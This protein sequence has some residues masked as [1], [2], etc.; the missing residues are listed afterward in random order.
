MAN[1]RRLLIKGDSMQL[2]TRWEHVMIFTAWVV[3][4]DACSGVPGF[5]HSNLVWLIPSWALVSVEG[6]HIWEKRDNKHSITKY[7][8]SVLTSQHK[9]TLHSQCTHTPSNYETEILL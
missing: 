9:S 2:K 5:P 1:D 8:I 7:F 3:M 4:L 6:N